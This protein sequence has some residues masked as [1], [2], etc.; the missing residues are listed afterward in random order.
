MPQTIVLPVLLHHQY[1]MAAL[2]PAAPALDEAA[3]LLA[4]LRLVAAA[5]AELCGI[6][7]A[8][9]VDT[10]HEDHQPEL[11]LGW[12]LVH[13]DWRRSR[14]PDSASAIVRANRELATLQAQIAQQ[15]RLVPGPP[16]AAGP[17]PSHVPHLSDPID[18]FA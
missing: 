3:V 12:R 5:T 4:T 8:R 2:L 13:R 17:R 11:T 15:R 7:A 6:Q 18:L 16:A 1:I 14:K 10:A 9:Q